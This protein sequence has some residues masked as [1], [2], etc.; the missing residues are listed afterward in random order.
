MSDTVPT[1]RRSPEAASAAATPAPLPFWR[2]SLR[3]FSQCAF[4]AN[5]VTG[6]FFIAA[7]TV[8][9][10]R[11]GVFFVLSVVLGTATAV[12]LRADAA[13]LDLGLF[14]F[15]SG[16]MGLAL[17]NFFHPNTA[18]WVAVVVLSVLVAA[19]TVAMARWVPWPFLAAPFIVMLWVI[20]PLAQTLHLAVVEL[21][22][23]G[24]SQPV[25]AVGT[26]VALGSTLFAAAVVPGL[27]FLVGV[28]LANW[29]HAAVAVL[30]AAIGVSLAIHV[31]APGDAINS[32]FVGFNAVLAALAAFVVIAE[33]LRMSILAA[34][35]ATWIFSAINR[36]APFP[37]LASGFVLTIWGLLLIAWINP[38][39]TG[40]RSTTAE[41]G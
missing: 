17:G 22:A 37:A 20:W 38:W 12:V 15:N 30:G 26:V 3:G 9:N 6:L 35:L 4:Q 34:V 41:A 13:L 11:M 36:S 39:F 14:G 31:G 7:A 32:G 5:E 1:T 8:F 23:F 25:F 2:R 16:L 33:D 24:N 27:L 10:W 40:S 28:A 29:R 18:L 19:L 21:A